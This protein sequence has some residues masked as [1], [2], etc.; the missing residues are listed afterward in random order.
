MMKH[1]LRPLK[2]IIATAGA[3]AVLALGGA[4][5]AFAAGETGVTITGGALSGGAA[6]FHDFSGIT[7][8]TDTTATSNWSIASVTDARGS[9]AGW[10]VS[11]TMSQLKEY[12]GGAYAASG[13]SLPLSS[14]KVSSASTV[15]LIGTS[16]SDASTITP[17]P[18]TTA[19]DTGSAVTLLSAGADGGMGTYS[20]S[21]LTATLS[22]RADAYALTY[23]S[24]ATISTNTAP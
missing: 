23:K 22:I 15:T 5:P 2:S 10:H 14:I 6:T 8:G 3:V 12:S 21:D 19:L 11:L 20:F 1:S 4:L 18:V 17:A 24:D 13:K 9:G 16:G 7:L